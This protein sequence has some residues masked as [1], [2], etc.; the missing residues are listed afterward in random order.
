MKS[1]VLTFLLLSF[2]LFIGN[3]PALRAENPCFRLKEVRVN[4]NSILSGR[5]VRKL[6]RE[7]RGT[8]VDPEVINLILR[9]LNNVC[10][11]QGYVTSRAVFEPQSVSSGILQVR[12]LEG[13]LESF[14]FDERSGSPWSLLNKT[15]T[16]SA[17]LGFKGE[18]LNLRDIEQGLSQMNRLSSKNI[19]MKIFPGSREDTSKIL[20]TDHGGQSQVRVRASADNS[21]QDSTGLYNAR[22]TLEHDNLFKFND[23][24]SL[25]YSQ[26]VKGATSQKRSESFSL[27]MGIPLGYCTLGASFAKSDY[28]TIIFGTNER[29]RNSGKGLHQ[30]Y[31]IERILLRGRRQSLSAW[32]QLNLKETESFIEDVKSEVGSRRMTVLKAGLGQ[33]WSSFLGYLNASAGYHRGLGFLGAKGDEGP[34]TPF[35][36]RAQFEKIDAS[37][38]LYKPFRA[39]GQNVHF[40]TLMGGQY[41]FAPLYSSEQ[42][43]IGDAYSVRGFKERS[44]F[45]DHGFY[46]SN[47]LGLSLPGFITEAW[48]INTAVRKTEWFGGFDVGQVRHFG[49]KAAN[50]GQGEAFLTGWATG[51]RYNGRRMNGEVTYS[52][53]VHTEDFIGISQEVYATLG[54]KLL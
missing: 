24:W 45:G 7:Y 31:K 15:Q 41:S 9:K 3:A 37:L 21:G 11:S 42:I 40:K 50:F 26:S 5:K 29:I 17:F 10:I 52:Q 30:N 12:I 23:I 44:A 35:T 28:S 46:A 13:K 36:P 4:K 14:E 20:L 8:C 19:T 43:V 6:A 2:G 18:P 34:S 1:K 53:S 51:L 27:S 48:G 22:L 25:S 32:T 38:S 16:L 49:G 47:E 39:L 33:T 54:L